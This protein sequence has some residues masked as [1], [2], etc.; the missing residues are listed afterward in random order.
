MYNNEIY[1]LCVIHSN[2]I[3]LNVYVKNKKNLKKIN[4]FTFTSTK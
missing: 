2:M 3:I 1:V 4:P